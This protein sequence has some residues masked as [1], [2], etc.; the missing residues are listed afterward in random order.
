MSAYFQRV[1]E[2]A[3]ADVQHAAAGQRNQTLNKAAFALGRHAHLKGANV[4]T[5]IFALNTAA[6][7]IGLQKHEIMATVG[8]G[9]K[10]GAENPKTLDET[11]LPF[12]PSELDR[13][14]GRLAADGLMARDDELRAEKVQKARMAWE[15][16]VAITKDTHDAVRPALR[17]LNGRNI[18][19]K[20]AVG[21]ARFSPDVYGGPAIIFPATDTSGEITGIQAVLIDE[22]GKKREH[23]GISK[24]SRGVIANS[25]MT[26]ASDR[27]NA[28]IIICEGPEDALSVAQAAGG[29]A[30]VICTFGKAGMATYVPPRASDVTICADP[31][32]DIERVADALNYDGSIRVSVVR[33]VDID[34]Q[35]KD[36]ND[37]L[38]DHGVEALR[39]ALAAAKPVAEQKAQEQREG[40]RGP[41]P[42]DVWD[43]AT[44]PPRKWV[45]G[46][47]YLR[48]FVSVLASA[49][50]V[51]K[52]SMISVEALA[53]C[54]GRALLGE[55]VCEPCKV[56][57]MN[58]EDPMEE[59]HRRFLAAMQHH[60][61]KR[62]E[63]E[64]RLYL[65][66]GRDFQA[67]FVTQTR[68]GVVINDALIE[69]MRERIVA[70]G[71]AVV[72]IDPWVG[73]I[74]INENDNTAM[75]KAVAAVR[76]IA[77][78]TGAAIVLVHHIRKG[79]GDEA[80][81]D[82]V[83]GAGSLIG[84]A[85][86]ARVINKVSEDD[87]MRLGVQGEDARGIF[88]VDDGKANLAPPAAAAVY[89]KMVGVQIGNGEWV[90]V[91][92]VFKMPDL[93]D[94]VTTRDTM[95]VQQA[96]GKAAQD[97]DPC[98]QSVQAKNWVGHTVGAVLGIDTQDKAG[99][100][101]VVAMVKKWL[102]TD[103]LRV[104]MVEDKRNGREAPCVVVGKWIT[105]DEAGL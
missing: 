51:G 87:M 69:Y 30:T 101:R 48:S 17:Y 65:D 64:G 99:K 29:A 18:A 58:L 81:V 84:A 25:A 90:G 102:E 73:A 20:S 103:V 88:R 59:M 42:F 2:T 83:R 52:T 68:D 28:P 62:D 105:G 3:I 104:E 50:G 78:E 100:G 66:A 33:F 40:F 13:L 74:D 57:V 26:I 92:E 76:Q 14:I 4:D 11:D 43:S 97:D 82:S 72:I 98:R 38:R 16:G 45:Y 91:A 79:N 12:Q 7:A 75:N 44:L 10:R 93:F 49:G 32:L 56:W 94:G 5:A 35:T 19:A 36:A 96:V 67:K 37:Y 85:R 6:E 8:S 53:I 61:V 9:F 15:R 89:R 41:T 70:E 22:N 80:T 54:T 31:D 95:R 1:T 21:V 71:I 60:G 86:A 27:E 46:R 34:A 24:Y 55:E 39:N 23:N 77:D 63:V 47:H